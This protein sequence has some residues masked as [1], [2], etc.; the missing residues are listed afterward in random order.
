MWFKC[1]G[2]GCWFIYL[3]MTDWILLPCLSFPELLMCQLLWKK[4]FGV[5]FKAGVTVSPSGNE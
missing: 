3:A 2:P 1:T 4:K 5:H